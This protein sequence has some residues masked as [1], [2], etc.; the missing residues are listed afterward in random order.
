MSDLED[1]YQDMVIDHN[2]RPRN[3][4]VLDGADRTADGYNP[5]CGDRLTLY[6]KMDGSPEANIVDVGFVGSGCAISRASASM[7]TESVKGKNTEEADRIFTAFRNMV[8]REPGAGF[9]PE[10]VGDLEMLAGVS[11]YPA[12]VKCATLA[13]HT[14]NNALHGSGNTASTE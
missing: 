4:G 14:L 13:W 7:M 5:L 9:D 10:E 3:Y 1:L 2:N 6:L 8:T 11:E 12:R